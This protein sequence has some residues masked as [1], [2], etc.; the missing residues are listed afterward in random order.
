MCRSFI[1]AVNDLTLWLSCSPQ[2]QQEVRRIFQLWKWQRL[3]EGSLFFNSKKDRDPFSA[4]F[5]AHWLET[6]YITPAWKNLELG[7]GRKETERCTVR[8]SAFT[9]SRLKKFSSE[10]KIQTMRIGQVIAKEAKFNC[11]AKPLWQCKWPQL[12]NSWLKMTCEI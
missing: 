6:R 10:Q 3:A 9:S 5:V 11:A 8:L 2:V 1:L 7:A 12:N 4:V